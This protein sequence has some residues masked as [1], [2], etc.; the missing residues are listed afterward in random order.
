[1][2]KTLSL[3][4]ISLHREVFMLKPPCP[5]DVE[6]KIGIIKQFSGYANPVKILQKIMLNYPWLSNKDISF[7]SGVTENQISRIRSGKVD[8]CKVEDLFRQLIIMPPS[9]RQE[10][11][12]ELQR[13]WVIFDEITEDNPASIKTFLGS[14]PEVGD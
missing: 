2:I 1:M 4:V 12:S 8:D 11:I 6:V 10:F 5:Q 3:F 13:Q 9:F 7:Q 14:V